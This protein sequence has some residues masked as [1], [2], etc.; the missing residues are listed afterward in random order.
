[1]KLENGIQE[2]VPNAAYHADRKCVSSTW[3]KKIQKTPFH[4]RLH[5]DTPPP[6]VTPPAL[7][8]GS[9]VDTLVFEP[10]L[11][12]KEFIIMPEL[13]LRTK[14]G[15]SERDRLIA[16]CVKTNQMLIK[17]S[18]HFIALQ[19]AKAVRMNPVM[20]RILQRGK[21]QQTFIW[22]DPVTELKCKCRTD[23]YDEE[24]AT[25]YDLKTAAD[26]SPEKFSKAIA[27]F[28]YHI[29][30]AFYSDGVRACNK[31]VERFV[32]CVQEKAAA[33]ETPNSELMA[34]YELSADDMQAGI[35]SYT[36]GL[37]AINFCMMTGEWT[38][39]TNQILPISRPVW[40]RKSDVEMVTSL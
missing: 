36:S 15:R 23:W 38:G 6:D 10:E 20:A 7:L 40:A 30:A 27:D 34:F 29:Q 16:K 25:I 12:K 37:A 18:D 9:A 2:G 5:L 22:D 19:T 33:G 32:F 26:A 31:P 24:D 8:M 39:Y 28:G 21:T 4:L 14:D 35:D 13:N 3:L 11:F 1:M 17:N